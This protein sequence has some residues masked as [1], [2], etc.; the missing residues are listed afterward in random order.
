MHICNRGETED[1]KKAAQNFNLWLSACN[2]DE[3]VVYT[4][5]SQKIGRDRKNS[6][7][8]NCLGHRMETAVVRH[9][10]VLSI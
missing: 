4:D 9:K 10:R 6:G 2:S 1:K 7:D 8:G 3:M 5:G